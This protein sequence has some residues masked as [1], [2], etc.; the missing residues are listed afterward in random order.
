MLKTFVTIISF[1]FLSVTAIAQTN[2]PSFVKGIFVDDYG[3][4]YS[5]NDTLWVQHPNIKSLNGMWPSSI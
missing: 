4:K 2:A 1:V 3:I 5:I